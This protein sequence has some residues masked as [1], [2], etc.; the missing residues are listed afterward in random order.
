MFPIYMF[1]SLFIWVASLHYFSG[2]RK[3]SHTHT[4]DAIW[5]LSIVEMPKVVVVV[6]GWEA[7][8]RVTQLT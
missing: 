8:R 6:T 4:C 7:T 1:V 3:R 2:K 5:Q